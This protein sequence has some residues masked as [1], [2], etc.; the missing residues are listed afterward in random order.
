MSSSCNSPRRSLKRKPSWSSSL[1]LLPL[2]VRT[3]RPAVSAAPGSIARSRAAA[4]SF[5][6]IFPSPL[7]ASSSSF[8]DFSNSAAQGDIAKPDARR[9]SSSW[10]A[11]P[12]PPLLP[13]LHGNTGGGA[14]VRSV[15]KPSSN[16]AYSSVCMQWSFM[17]GGAIGSSSLTISSVFRSTCK[18]CSRSKHAR[19]TCEGPLLELGANNSLNNSSLLSSL[20]LLSSSLSSSPSPSSSSSS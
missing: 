1:R 14:N 6:S 13:H 9:T 15:P 18:L 5:P 20:S 11:P 4:S 7:S 2:A 19:S 17:T 10:F 12:P 3:D 8:S 16:G